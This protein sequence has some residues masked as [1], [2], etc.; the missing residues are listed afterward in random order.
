MQLEQIGSIP[1]RVLTSFCPKV[2]FEETG[3][4]NTD[5]ES[6][7]NYPRMITGVEIAMML[8]EPNPGT[9]RASLRSNGKAKV[10]ELAVRFGGGGHAMAAGASLVLLTD[11]SLEDTQHS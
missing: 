11:M 7:V 5:L 3:T 9:T 2:F 8:S 4:V 6:F 10:N 1:D